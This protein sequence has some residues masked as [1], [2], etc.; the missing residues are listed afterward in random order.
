MAK[1]SVRQRTLQRAV[2]VLLLVAFAGFGS[3]AANLARIQLVDG[4]K[5]R[6]K[7][8]LNQLHDTV[9]AAER[10]TIYDTNGSILAQSASV[11]KVYIKPFRIDNET[12]RG[13]LV[14]KLSS[15]LNL[16]EES[17]RKKTTYTQYEYLVVKS[18]VELKEKNEV[19]EFAKTTY[20]DKDDNTCYYSNIIGIDP[21][22][23]RY[24][25]YGNF[26]SGVIGFTGTDGIGRS[27]I[28]LKYD[29]VLTGTPG[30]IITAQN[31]LNDIMP[32]QYETVHDAKQGTSLVLTID[33]VIQR[34]LE[35]GLEQVHK[36]SKGKGAYGIVMDVHTGAIL[37]MAGKPDFDLNDPQTIKDT[38][39]AEEIGKIADEKKRSEATNNARFAQWRNRP[40]GDTYEPGSVF[41]I[42]TASAALEEKTWPMDKKYTC[43]GKVR[44]ENRI[45]SCWKHAGHGTQTITQG[46]MN[47]CNPFFINV[48]QSVGIDNFCKYFE[49]FGFTEKTGIDLPAEAAPVAGVT[50]HIKEKMG[51]VE[52]SSSSFGQSINIT[53][54]QMITAAS[55]IA[56]GGKLM[57][58]YV[59]SRMLDEQGNVVHVTEPYVRR[60]VISESTA[61]TMRDMMEMVVSSGTGKNAYVAGY[62]VAGKTG[63]S[64]KLFKEGAYVASF[65]CFAPANDPKIAVLITIDEPVGQINGGQ[66]AAPVA[67]GVIENTLIYMNVEPHYNEKELWLLNTNAPGMIG[68]GI[69]DAKAQLTAGGFSV[70]VLG[71]G[72]TVL[73]QIPSFGQSLPKNGVVV[74]YTE[75]KNKSGN[76]TVP[77][78]NGLTITQANKK[79]AAAGLNIKISGNAL[80]TGELISYRQSV[81]KGEKVNYGSVIT[82]YFK[83][84]TGVSETG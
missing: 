74:L 72:K 76:T 79:A 9:I 12:V 71:N 31:G 57:R 10:G 28:E 56:N 62:H 11:W 68:K 2:I 20:K 54:I 35:K 46:L 27:G 15:I 6:K 84:N 49:A 66:I 1:K 70:K 23:K 4:E 34:Y 29:S 65:V 18:Q 59:V 22:V 39:L 69:E 17:V 36:D 50:Y 47:S 5:Y 45:I 13:E 32:L 82:V 7:A 25:P 30:R 60:Q 16:E 64:E 75:E 51:I 77:D 40:I 37:A 53:P 61:Q 38:A 41:K 83:S 63:T 19:V 43:V 24:Y 14:K 67:A 80:K 3:S 73:S 44:V 55:C 21:D 42:I 58:P 26:A 33:E 8:E 81:E 52:L 48:G 78:L